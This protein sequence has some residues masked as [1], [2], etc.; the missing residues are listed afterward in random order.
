M[1]TFKDCK[2]YIKSDLAR[3]TKVNRKNVLK[4]LIFNS[5]FKITFWFRLGKYLKSK[6]NIYF[7]HKRNQLNTGIQI[8]FMTKCGE[9]LT[10]PH[11]SNIVIKD[12]PDGV[13]VAGIPAKIINNEGR[14]NVLMYLE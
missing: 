9:G 1:M 4:Y 5:S 10:F 12:V 11:F 6:E 8:A 7:I 3:L 13:T 14:K 2:L